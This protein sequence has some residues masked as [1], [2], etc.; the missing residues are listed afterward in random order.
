MTGVAVILLAGVIGYVS[1]MVRATAIYTGRDACRL[2]AQSEIEVAKSVVNA[3][4]IRSIERS[5]HIVGGDTIG[6]TSVS[7]FDWFEAYSGTT[8]KRTIGTKNPV[9]L[10]AAITNMGCVVKVRIGTVEHPVGTQWA[11][12]T[13]VA[14]AERT[15][16][17][18]TVSSTVAET[19]RFAQQ[20]SKV[21]NNAYFVNN[22]GWFQGTGC[23]ANGD[24]RANGDM[25]LD[26]SCKVNGKVYAARNEELGV[27]G[28]ITN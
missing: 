24:V 4:F 27:N 22:Y 8:A 17:G 11:N 1:W 7:S 10:D 19:V 12:V 15:A 5:A 3:A 9:T 18:T 6:S 20:R 23:T 13:F 21:F 16:L 14:K 28:D 26:S 2:A 25:Y